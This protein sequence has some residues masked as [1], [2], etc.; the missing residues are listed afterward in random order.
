MQT[1]NFDDPYCEANTQKYI[2]GIYFSCVCCTHL[3]YIHI[4]LQKYEFLKTVSHLN[5]QPSIIIFNIQYY[6]HKSNLAYLHTVRICVYL[7]SINHTSKTV[8][9]RSGTL[10]SLA[11]PI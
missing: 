1:Q 3:K 2:A 6:T 8:A 4:K 5:E 7:N 11:T 9:S 10:N